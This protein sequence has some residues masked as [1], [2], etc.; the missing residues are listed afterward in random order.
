MAFS[1][2]WRINRAPEEVAA[3]KCPGIECFKGLKHIAAPSVLRVWVVFLRNESNTIIC[4]YLLISSPT[5]FLLIAISKKSLYVQT[6]YTSI[7][8][9]WKSSFSGLNE[10]CQIYL[11]R[12]PNKETVQSFPITYKQ[13]LSS[14]VVLTSVYRFKRPLSRAILLSL[15]LLS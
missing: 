8:S 7:L 4:P 3:N 15:S 12:G 6:A 13:F 5:V 14:S 1:L 10:V 2:Q 11:P 9:S